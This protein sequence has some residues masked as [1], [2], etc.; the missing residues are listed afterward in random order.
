MKGHFKTSSQLKEFSRVQ[1]HNRQIVIGNM[2]RFQGAPLYFAV[3][4]PSTGMFVPV[5]YTEASEARK[6]MMPIR[7]VSFTNRP[8]QVR[9]L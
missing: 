7:S 5:M 9:A 4:P 2:S 6:T 8:R 3:Y 1:H